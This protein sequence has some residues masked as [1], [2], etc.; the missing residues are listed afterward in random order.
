MTSLSIAEFM[1]R[2]FDLT[3]A[4]LQVSVM[5]L[6]RGLESAVVRAR[7]TSS[8]RRVPARLVVKHLQGFHRR[9][10]D[11]Y[12]AMATLERPPLAGVHGVEVRGDALF[13]YL[14]DLEAPVEWPWSDTGLA[15]EVCR[16]LAALHRSTP[17]HNSVDDWDYE[18]HLTASALSTLALSAA[19]LDANGVR[20]WRRRGDLAR[21]VRCLPWIRQ[22]LAEQDRVLIHGDLHPGNVVVIAGTGEGRVRLIDWACARYGSPF[23]D[24]ASWLHSLGCW[25]PE[26]RRRHDSL[27]AA[28]LRAAM[29]GCRISPDLRVT[30]WL[31]AA[32]NGLSGAI[33][34]H[35]AV[36][37]DP[38][39]A[40]P[41][42]GASR[43]A[44]SEWERVIRRAASLLTAARMSETRQ[45]LSR[46]P[47]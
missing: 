8:D 29:P 16:T 21:V 13:L 39:S 40:A 10:A 28:Y 5:P 47:S 45:S 15:V 46:S 31:A 6:Q 27:L 18:A 23:E 14:E 35:L 3:P 19:A 17:P 11:V 24:V 34:Y 1:A 37:G 33:R 22:H 25:E 36:I 38:A 42:R 2:R 30:Y 4:D 41:L 44:L 26:A 32:C 20:I 12:A 9:E 7:I 43:A